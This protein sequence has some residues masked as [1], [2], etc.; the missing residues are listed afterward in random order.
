[1]RPTINQF[2]KQCKSRLKTHRFKQSFNDGTC[3]EFVF[4][5][6]QC[7]IVNHSIDCL[8]LLELMFSKM[9]LRLYDIN[10][11]YY[12]YYYKYKTGGN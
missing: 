1:M 3:I 10:K 6:S 2:Q 5:I 8:M 4:Y 9:T 11:M 7:L 12:Y